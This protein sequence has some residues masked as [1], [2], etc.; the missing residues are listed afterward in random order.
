MIVGNGV[1][2][3]PPQDF[4]QLPRCYYPVQNIIK[5]VFVVVTYGIKS[6]LNFINFRQA[7]LQL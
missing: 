7:I 5:C 4:K 3:N 1:I 2:I 6:T